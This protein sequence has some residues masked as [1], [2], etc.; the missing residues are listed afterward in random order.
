[1]TNIKL[2]VG[3]GNAKLNDSILTVSLPA[4]YTCP[5]A[6]DCLSKSNPLTGRII[7]GKHCQFRCYAASQECT[8]P[9]V[10]KARWHNFN[11]LKQAKSVEGMSQ[12]IQRSL[13]DGYKTVRIHPS[14]DYYNEKYFLAWLNVALNNPGIMFYGYTKAT[15][16]IVEYRKYIPFNFRLV[17][18]KGGTHD[19]LI[20]KYNLRSA[21]VV[22]SVKEAEDKGL[23]IDHDD[24]LAI[25]GINSFGLLLHGIQPANTRAGEALKELRKQGLGGYSKEKKEMR[26]F[27]KKP[28]YIFLDLNKGKIQRQSKLVNLFGEKAMV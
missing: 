24:S 4:G 14:G 6:K 25:N 7:D 12:V 10:R 23:L 13:V 2:K 27:Q 5:F 22:F 28:F 3:F 16:L 19:H 9:N 15:P 1:M 26:H 11:I 18:S 21:E 8:Y 20:K 17:A